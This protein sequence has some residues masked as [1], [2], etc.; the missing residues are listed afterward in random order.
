MFDMNRIEPSD[1][2]ADDAT[3]VVYNDLG[4]PDSLHRLFE[5]ARDLR[6]F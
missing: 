1:R 2:T 6:G 3:G 5:K 4:R